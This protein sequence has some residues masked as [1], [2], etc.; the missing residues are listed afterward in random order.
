M[1]RELRLFFFFVSVFSG[2]S[3]DV[4]LLFALSLLNI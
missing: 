4:E 1:L 2:S 3:N